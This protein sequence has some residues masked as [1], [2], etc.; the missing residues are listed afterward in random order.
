[1]LNIQNLSFSYGKTKVLQNFN[2]SLAPGE[3][4]SI[5]GPSGCGKS[6]L[7]HLIAGLRK[8]SGG[9]LKVNTQ[10]I[11]YVFQEPRLLPWLT[12]A[13]NLAAVLPNP[14]SGAVRIESALR[15]VG[16]TDAKEL[17]PKELSGG[18]KIRVS[19]ARALVYGGNLVLLDEPFSA[20][21]EDLRARLVQDLR[22]YFKRNAITAILVTHQSADAEGF[23]D[24]VLHL[25]KLTE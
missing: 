5:M 8:P 19:L 16:L 3:L 25:E 14:K 6:T 1:M 2:L 15:L 24:R 17:Y 12:V 18:M 7:L 23:A 10:R 22:N 13:Q 4:L 20:L 21:D 11:S 9:T